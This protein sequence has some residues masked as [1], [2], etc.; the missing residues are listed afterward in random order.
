M[1]RYLR[2][3]VKSIMMIIVVLFVVSCF[4]G[5]GMY[6][7][8]GGNA[9]EGSGE[10][11]TDYDVAVVDGERIRRSRVETEMFQMIRNL[12]PQ[13][14]SISEDDYPSL[15]TAVLDQI[16]IASEMDKEIKARN[17]TVTDDEVGNTIKDIESSFPTREIYF[18]EMKRAGLDEKKL[19]D[20][21]RTE[22][23]RQ[24]L[25]DQVTAPVS[26]DESELKSFYDMMKAYYFQKP[27]GFKV[28]LAH[29][30][31][32]ESAERVRGAITGGASWDDAME[33][34]SGDV[35]TQTP[36]D[37]PVLIPTDQFTGEAESLKD[38][39]FDEISDVTMLTSD[40]FMLVIKRSKEESGTADFDEVSADI[41]Q[42]ILG[43]KRQGSQSEFLRELRTQA[44]VQILDESIFFTPEPLTS[45]DV[46]EEEEDAPSISSDNELEPVSDSKPETESPDE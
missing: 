39:P 26:T 30:S 21:I 14:Q 28:N 36:F 38:F 3:N 35:M 9:G 24:K 33:A 11:M 17:I 18:Q 2:K 25:F 29:F 44:N 46:T 32:G 31:S 6:N 43:Q 15:R 10:G 42:M 19:R 37:S 5:Y 41:E 8:N 20:T 13:G 40:D 23:A 34:A 12:G 16:A 4:A 27:E 22:L 7:N 45:G 1:M